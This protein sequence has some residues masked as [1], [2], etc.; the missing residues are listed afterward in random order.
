MPSFFDFLALIRSFQAIPNA[1]PF[2][3]RLKM[4]PR[5]GKS[6]RL[7][8]ARP[9]TEMTRSASSAPPYSAGV[10]SFVAPRAWTW[11]QITGEG[12]SERSKI[13]QNIQ[14]LHW[15]CMYLCILVALNYIAFHYVTLH[16]IALHCI[17]LHSI[18]FHCI[19]LHSIAFHCITLRCT[20]F[21]TY[22]MY[23]H[24]YI[25]Y[26]RA[27]LSWKRSLS[28]ASFLA[29]LSMC[30]ELS[31]A[32]LKVPRST[33][34]FP[35]SSTALSTNAWISICHIFPSIRT[36]IHV[37]SMHPPVCLCIRYP[38]VSVDCWPTSSYL[39]HTR[40]IRFNT[41]WFKMC[42]RLCTIQTLWK[43]IYTQDKRNV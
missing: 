14:T 28:V 6:S 5:S 10:L 39:I 23:L 30:P 38:C 15:H 17:P 41:A 21:Y 19:T 40:M 12:G 1:T 13:M 35:S 37:S 18:A 36:C 33:L 27:Y 11:A 20:T 31:S 8:F 4:C 43:A 16:S 3:W 29:P 9:W 34:I 22:N 25:Y 26:V 32:W 42:V 24:T 7:R 2:V